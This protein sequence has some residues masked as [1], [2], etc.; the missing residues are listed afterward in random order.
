[1]DDK[2]QE[3]GISLEDL[4]FVILKN[5]RIIL[6][7]TILALIL[8]YGYSSVSHEEIYTTTASMVVNSKQVKLLEG[9]VVLTNDIYLSQKMVNTYRVILLSDNVLEKVNKDIEANLSPAQMREWITVESPKD[10]EVIS[11]T[12]RNTD[13][14]LAVQ[15]ANSM[16]RVAPEVISQTVEV[17]SINVLDYAKVP[18]DPDEVKV[19]L[20]LS[21]GGFLGLLAGI[22][23]S[24]LLFILRPTFRTKEQIVENIQLPV[25]GS[26][27]HL[28]IDYSLKH[29]EKSLVIE[30]TIDLVFK[31]EYKILAEKVCFTAKKKGSKNLIVTSTGPTEG[32][33]TVSANL[34]LTLAL[35]GKKVLLIDFDY[36]K[37]GLMDLFAMRPEYFLNDIFRDGMNYQDVLI[38]ETS[39]NLDIIFSKPE[40]SSQADWSSNL[41][42][43]LFF[44][45]IRSQYD[46]VIM[47]TPPALLK[48]DVLA[49]GKF[50]DSVVFVI[51]QEKESI[52]NIK[53]AQSAFEEMEMP[54]L[55]CILNDIKYKVG[56]NYSYK[57]AYARNYYE[58]PSLIKVKSTRNKNKMLVLRRIVFFLIIFSILLTIAFFATRTDEEVIQMSDEIITKISKMTG[59]SGSEDYWIAAMEY[60]IHAVLF[61]L[62]TLALLGLFSTF[63]VRLPVILVLSFAISLALSVG[64]EYFQSIYVEGRIFEVI[65]VAFGVAGMVLGAI[66]FILFKIMR[67]VGFRH[68]KHGSL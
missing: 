33:S 41:N 40:K 14:S 52:K 17:G 58:D 25:F 22:L 51:R 18:A 61:F 15:I 30:P 24:F 62:T 2:I 68:E 1:M 45:R 23:L 43:K 49:L 11:V 3:E 64:N 20:N 7:S 31:E 47:D 21:V 8:A 26:I 42:L 56:S 34:A 60:Y 29:K 46:F 27:P 65:D 39:S 36:Y 66:V 55:G 4:F 10:T 48:K 35:S 32:K 13:P 57:Y 28:N 19:G 59:D 63:F 54:I 50:A 38:N 12:I 16:M 67:S 44:E 9:E 5:W 6:V 37:D 53:E